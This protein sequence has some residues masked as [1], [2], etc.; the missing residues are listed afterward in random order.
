MR[1]TRPQP[2]RVYSS[3]HM[4]LDIVGSALSVHSHFTEA[5]QAEL[6]TRGE[7]EK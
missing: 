3:H 2:Q 7:A 6:E 1:W 4:I 5:Q